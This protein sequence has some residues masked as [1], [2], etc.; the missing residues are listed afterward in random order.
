MAA[1]WEALCNNQ[2]VEMG[3]KQ[4]IVRQDP[5]YLPARQCRKDPSG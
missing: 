3:N 5:A 1:I 4:T 2:Y